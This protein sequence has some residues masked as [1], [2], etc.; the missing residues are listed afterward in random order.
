MNSYE[1]FEEVFEKYNKKI[2]SLLLSLTKNTEE[3]ED[4]TQETFVKCYKK[5]DRFREESKLY[6][7]LHR[8][9]INCWKNKV[10]YNKRRGIYKE[11]SL[12]AMQDDS[13]EGDKIKIRNTE[14][15]SAEN[16]LKDLELQRFVK[17][18]IHALPPKYKAPIVLYMEGYSIGEIS[19]IIKRRSGTVKSL[20]FRAKLKLKEEI[21]KY[22]DT[23][24]QNPNATD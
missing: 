11:D 24:G 5:L 7:W 6:T 15:V 2:F 4:L 19:A 20:I 3:A 10:R 18:C 12:D 8:I 13:V 1:M 16:V 9:A 14:D 21:I 17:K 23:T 22:L